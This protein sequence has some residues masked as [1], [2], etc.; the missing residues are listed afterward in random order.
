MP[1]W[2]N[3]HWREIKDLYGFRSISFS[4][5]SPIS[6]LICSAPSYWISIGVGPRPHGSSKWDW[7]LPRTGH[8]R[9]GKPIALANLRRAGTGLACLLDVMRISLD[10]D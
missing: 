5:I 10:L 7:Y 9:D 6:V 3:G 2:E 4:E 8:Y 1:A